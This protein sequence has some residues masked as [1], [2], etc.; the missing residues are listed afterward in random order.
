[1]TSNS[2][3]EREAFGKRL[4][5]QNDETNNIEEVQRCMSARCM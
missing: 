5:E 3:Q 4:L 2:P 1:M